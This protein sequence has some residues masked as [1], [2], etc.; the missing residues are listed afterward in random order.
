MDPLKSIIIDVKCRTILKFEADGKQNVGQD[1][2]CTGEDTSCITTVDNTVNI[3]S[4]NNAG[5]HDVERSTQ[6][7]NKCDGGANCGNSA[8]STITIGDSSSDSSSSSTDTSTENQEEPSDVEASISA[9]TSSDTS[10]SD[11]DKD[12]DDRS[13]DQTSDFGD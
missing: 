5:S 8:S 11:N 4:N 3:D 7:T 10:G 12:N 6:Q 9:A 13:S 2:K 1:N